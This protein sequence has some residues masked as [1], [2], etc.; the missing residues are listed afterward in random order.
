MDRMQTNLSS[1]IPRAWLGPAV[2]GT[3]LTLIGT[4][5]GRGDTRADSDP[6][7]GLPSIADTG[8]PVVTG[9][10]R[11]MTQPAQGTTPGI[12][13]VGRPS[14]ASGGT[15]GSLPAPSNASKPG[16]TSGGAKETPEPRRP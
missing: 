6:G 11:E 12:N 1:L 7:P 8:Q 15:T 3:V 2:L 5:C 13:S 14:D 10:N 4:G 16:S 9:T